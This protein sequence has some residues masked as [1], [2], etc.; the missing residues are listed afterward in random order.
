LVEKTPVLVCHF[1]GVW[2]IHPEK[3]GIFYQLIL[4]YQEG[5]ITGDNIGV[6]CRMLTVWLSGY[7][8]VFIGW[9]VSVWVDLLWPVVQFFCRWI[10]HSHSHH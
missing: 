2:K 9:K 7:Q 10:S 3:Y 1:Y 8:S 6:A 4:H 5:E